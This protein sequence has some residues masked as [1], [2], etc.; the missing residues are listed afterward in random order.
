[1]HRAGL[2]RVTFAL[3]LALS[4][5]HPAAGQTNLI[6]LAADG[7]WTWFNDPRALVQSGVLFFGYVRA[8]DSRTTLSAFDLATGRITE[9]W[10]SSRTQFDDHNNPGLLLRPDGR[11]VAIYARHSTDTFFACRVSTLANPAT[12]AAWGAEQIIPSTGAGVTYANPYQLAAESGQVYDFCRD[13]NFNPTVLTS[14][15]GGASWSAP[16][17]F[18]KTGT[19][20][21]RPYVKYASDYNR[22][23]DFLYT[24]G[25]PRDVDNSLYHAYYESGALYRTDGSLLKSFSQLPLLHDSGERGTVIY[26]YSAAAT[27]DPNDHIPTGRAWCWE[28]TAQT[29]GAPACVFSV[30]RDLVTG[31]NWT[32]DRIYYY[33]ARWT[34]TNWQKRFIAHAGRPLY[35]PEDD[36]AGGIALDPEAP[37][38]VYV[39]T[40][41][42]SP[43]DLSTTTNV[44]LRSHF[45]IF[46][47]VTTN[48]GLNFTWTA[49][50]TNSTVD[51]LR[52]YVPR[53]RQG[54]PLLLWFRGSYPT[55]TSFNTSVV[56]LF[57]NTSIPPA[58][59]AQSASTTNCVGDTVGLWAQATG[60]PPLAWQ[61]RKDGQ[62]IS[63]LANPTAT[64]ASLVLP[65]VQ[66]ADGGAYSALVINP[67]GAATS[68]VVQLTVLPYDPITNGLV[69]ALDVDLSGAT[70]TQPGFQRFAL[71]G[72]GATFDRSVQVAFSPVG[73][74]SL[75]ERQRST[76]PLVTNNPPAL[77]Q[78]R[79][80]ND[81]IF[82]SSTADGAGLRIVISRLAPNT[83]FGLTLWS[84]DPQ[85]PGSRVSDWTE[86][87]SGT[88]LPIVTGYA[89]NGSLP[90][91]ADY[92]H[93]FGAR[94]ISSANGR[95]QLEGVRHGGTSYGVFVNGLELVA[96]P[97]LRITQARLAANGNLRLSVAA[98]YPGQALAFQQSS[99][100]SFPGWQPATGG[101]IIEQYGPRSIVE[102][103]TGAGPKFYR[104]VSP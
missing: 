99:N 97:A 59:L 33:Y 29:N 48:S 82:A 96:E 24:D 93:T 64:N 62:P 36:Y 11:I 37:S 12:P 71:D 85:S 60:T 17:L 7:A 43:F 87:S 1:M 58:I 54:V 10:T 68:S 83:P 77:S 88:P 31:T 45:E 67:A 19:G 5:S 26:Q 56:G 66:F 44:P 34:G 52:P 101:A 95:L 61:W 25:H 30:Q 3:G 16:Q 4:L 63:P 20:S 27:L 104:V 57:T 98:Q 81:F 21:T 18:I 55:F 14:T 6:T 102:F 76:T 75:A 72:N 86:T 49:I 78:A 50:T 100:L 103:P 69:L 94:L 91:S 65:A 41:A 42:A 92:D 13:L 28:I 51:N 89:F 32:D 2:F 23:L 90:P 53:N 84:F 22:R 46:K 8:A 47:G 80:Y 70:N 9:L 79:L 35:N 74:A 15:N 40:D 39:S 38:V 73:N